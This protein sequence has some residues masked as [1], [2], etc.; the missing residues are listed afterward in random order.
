M[1][2]ALD[3]FYRVIKDNR[4]T[5]FQIRRP[6]H[7]EILSSAALIEH[8]RV[9]GSLL[10]GVFVNTD[11]GWMLCADFEEVDFAKRLLRRLH[12]TVRRPNLFICNFMEELMHAAINFPGIW[13][14]RKLAILSGLYHDRLSDERTRPGMAILGN[15]AFVT[16][17]T[18]CKMVRGRKIS[19]T[20]TFPDSAYLS[21]ADLIL[22]RVYPRER[23]SAEWEVR[24]VKGKFPRLTVQL[25]ANAAKILRL[26]ATCRYIYKFK[27]RFVGLNHIRTV[28]SSSQNAD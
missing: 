23:K 11:G 6:N 22:Q 17:N 18:S 3:V 26:I 10:T 2:Y 1:D 28:H 19:E 14:D 7:E 27:T 15:T 24:A 12:A 8:D 13:H 21:A 25:P 4:E 20:A 5:A 9:N 16:K